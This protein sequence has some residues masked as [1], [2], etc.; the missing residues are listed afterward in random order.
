MIFVAKNADASANNLG[1]ISI[2]SIDD[3][4]QETY[5][6]IKAYGNKSFTDDQII[7]ID[8]FLI[9]LRM[10][11]AYSHITF[12]IAPILSPEVAHGSLDSDTVFTNTNV[13][14]DLIS[15]KSL[16][17]SGFNGYVDK[18]GLRCWKQVGNPA[19]IYFNQEKE[20]ITLNRKILTVGT[21]LKSRSGDY[22]FGGFIFNRGIQFGAVNN[23]TSA[24]FDKVILDDSEPIF[25]VGSRNETECIG[26]RNGVKSTNVKF[27]EEPYNGDTSQETFALQTIGLETED[28]LSA[29]TPISLH[30]LCN[31]YSMTEDELMKMND[32]C[33]PLL[34]ALW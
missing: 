5:D 3:V 22:G 26:I 8:D 13:S 24:E 20:P 29:S 32:I 23:V 16:P 21:C 33:Y 30:F 1:K 18:H 27:M 9:G 12:F 15:K 17:V 14:Y 10:H 19:R 7:A 28:P 25:T 34:K 6:V 11:P 31:G 2:K 4:S